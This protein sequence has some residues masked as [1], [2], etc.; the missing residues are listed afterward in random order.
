MGTQNLICVFYKGQSVIARYTK[1]N[2]E[3][4]GITILKF[5]QDSANIE[6]LKKGLQHTYT[7]DDEELHQIEKVDSSI[8]SPLEDS[9]RYVHD[10]AT[11][12]E[13]GD[14][15]LINRLTAVKMDPE[16]LD[17]WIDKLSQDRL[18]QI[19]EGYKWIIENLIHVVNEEIGRLTNKKD[20]ITERLQRLKNRLQHI[21][22]NHE[23]SQAIE[24]AYALGEVNRRV[25]ELIDDSGLEYDKYFSLT[26]WPSLSSK[27]GA[28]ILKLVAQAT[29]EK[30]LP[31]HLSLE[32]VNDRL[33]CEW[34]YMIDLDRHEFEVHQGCEAKDN[35][36]SKRFNSIGKMKVLL[37]YLRRRGL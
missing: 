13:Q 18:Q 22:P 21:K 14:E 12:I 8:I 20:A 6:N 10:E 7:L 4:E 11:Q 26:L 15:R 17:K 19:K 27:T 33:Y 25:F 37:S 24:D 28:K 36:T 30:C 34:A 32:F 5:L 23:F 9:F 29:G 31:I 35:A 1:W 3:G 2:P 16:E